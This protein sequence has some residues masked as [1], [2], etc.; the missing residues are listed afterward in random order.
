MDKHFYELFDRRILQLSIRKHRYQGK[1]ILMSKSLLG[2]GIFLQVVQKDY[3]EAHQCYQHATL[4]NPSNQAIQSVY[5]V[6][7]D[8]GYGAVSSPVLQRRKAK[9]QRLASKL[10]WRNK[11]WREKMRKEKEVEE[12]KKKER[13]KKRKEM[14]KNV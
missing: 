3:Y 2:R 13:L 4:L 9:I 1:E 8:K 12:Q 6:F 14:R 11:K 10:E 7:I 5:N